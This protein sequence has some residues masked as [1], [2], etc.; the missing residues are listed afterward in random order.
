MS[1][2]ERAALYSQ[3]EETRGSPL[4][5][6][7]TSPRANAGG[8]MGGDVVPEFTKHLLTIPKSNDKIDILIVSNG[9]DPTVSWRIISLL[10]ERFEK[11]GVLLPFAA[12]SAATLIALGADEIVMHPF[13]NLGPVDPQLVYVRRAPGGPEQR[14]PQ[15]KMQF[16]AEDLRYFLDFVRQDVQVSDQEQMERAFEYLCKDVGSVPIGIAKRSSQLSLSLGE[17]LLSLHM[18]DQNRVKAIAEAL[19]RSFYHHGYP[20]GKTEAKSIGLPVA[21]PSGELESLMWQVWQDV[22][23]EMLGNEPFNP[24]KCVLDDPNV[25][26]LLE[27]VQQIQ[28]PANLPPQA[29]NQILQSVIQ[30]IGMVSVPP[31]QFEH[32][33]AV[34]ESRNCRSEFRTRGK[35]NAIRRPDMTIA[36]NVM[37]IEQQ[38]TTISTE[39]V[40]DES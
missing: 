20:V 21:D 24:L 1:Y 2:S 5:C 14:G 28:I 22:E 13:A 9:G 31:V 19:N 30:Q 32:L 26:A 10:R 38:W 27:P 7:V 15:E 3:I 12:Y 8:Q 23:A 16:G 17:K 34:L 6:Y 33:Q 11:V 39:G 29:T 4:L 37:R 25:A 40:S 18:D 35:I 36:T